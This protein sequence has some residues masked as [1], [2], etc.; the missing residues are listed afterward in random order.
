QLCQDREAGVDLLAAALQ[1]VE[2]SDEEFLDE[3]LREQ[4]AENAEKVARQGSALWPGMNYE[5]EVADLAPSGISLSRQAPSSQFRSSNRAPVQ[6]GSSS[7]APTQGSPPSQVQNC[8][9]IS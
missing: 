8:H 7:Q 5:V 4:F 1:V 3:H 6:S 2:F 9:N